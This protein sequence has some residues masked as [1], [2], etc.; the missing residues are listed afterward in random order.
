MDSSEFVSYSTS[1]IVTVPRIS[2]PVNV[3]LDEKLISIQGVES[4]DAATQSCVFPIRTA[5][6][7]ASSFFCDDTERLLLGIKPF[8]R[9]IAASQI[10]DVAWQNRTNSYIFENKTKKNYSRSVKQLKLLLLLYN[11]N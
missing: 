1:I 9:P 7:V 5:S 6:I 2:K 10:Y 4:E 3:L 11:C 8:S